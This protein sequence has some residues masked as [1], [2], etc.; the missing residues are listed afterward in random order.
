[1]N[2]NIDEKGAKVKFPPPLI[3]LL[4]LFCG[5]GAHYLYPLSIGY[6]WPVKTVGVIL[7]LITLT[8]LIYIGGIFKRKETNIEPWKPTTAIIST[9]IYAYS[10]N[11]IYMALCLIS[12]GVGVVVD[13]IWM[14]LSFLP[15]ALLVYWIAI[16]KE[17]A[18]LE[19]KFGEEYLSYKR[20]V[21]RWL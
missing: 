16:K 13:S 2:N 7:I 9:G 15:S 3:Y 12:I 5:Y 20:K 21:R 10:R 1:M 4:C 11:P 14:L 19:H 8:I 6:S 17:E 18:Y